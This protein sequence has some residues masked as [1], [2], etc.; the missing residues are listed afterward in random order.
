MLNYEAGITLHYIIPY[1]IVLVSILAGVLVSNL[2][3]KDRI[4]RY[5]KSEILK[6]LEF[7]ENKIK[8]YKVETRNKDN[9]IK[10]L[11]ARLRIIKQ[12]EV[13]ILEELE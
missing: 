7:Q 10:Q 8:S 2:F 13:R 5:A 1:L 12:H 6:T 11:E 9:K 4:Y 3:W